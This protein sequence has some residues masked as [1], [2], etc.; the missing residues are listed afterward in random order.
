MGLTPAQASNHVTTLLTV[1]IEDFVWPPL[2]KTKHF[3]SLLTQ[4]LRK[5]ERNVLSRP[6]PTANYFIDIISIAELYLKQPPAAATWEQPLHSSCA[7]AGSQRAPCTS[8]SPTR[9]CLGAISPTTAFYTSLVSTC[10]L[11][12]IGSSFCRSA[13]L[14]G[15]RALGRKSASWCSLLRSYC[16]RG[17]HGSFKGLGISVECGC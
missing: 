5:R 8:S 12:A 14:A 6:I 9:C 13:A 16:C 11:A 15:A 3:I 4:Q 7:A 1:M 2:L 10:R 17:H